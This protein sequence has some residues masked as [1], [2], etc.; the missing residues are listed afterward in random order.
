METL[1]KPS[2]PRKRESRSVRFGAGMTIWWDRRKDIIVRISLALSLVAIMPI[3]LV[4]ACAPIQPTPPTVSLSA[5]SADVPDV[6]AYFDAYSRFEQIVTASSSNTPPDM[7]RVATPTTASVIATMSDS[8]KFLVKPHFEPEHM[9][10][11]MDVCDKANR[12]VMVYALF[13]LGMC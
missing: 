12:A 2:F 7:P 11:L 1:N 8:E 3:A 5:A 13:D 10:T 9:G 6:S 4:S